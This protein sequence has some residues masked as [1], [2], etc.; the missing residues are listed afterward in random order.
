MLKPADCTARAPAGRR[1]LSRGRLSAAVK[2]DEDFSRRQPHTAIWRLEAC[3]PR[4][5]WGHGVG[6]CR[7]KVK[8]SGRRARV[9]RRLGG[10]SRRRLPAK[11]HVSTLGYVFITCDA[12]GHQFSDNLSPSVRAT[13][14]IASSAGKAVEMLR[15]AFPAAPA[16]MVHAQSFECLSPMGKLHVGRVAV[17]D[18]AGRASSRWCE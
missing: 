4:G 13:L 18:L 8:A 9:S 17:V 5:D 1:I 3:P 7:P 14:R 6:A 10:G 16:V 12:P 2:K 11:R 15:S